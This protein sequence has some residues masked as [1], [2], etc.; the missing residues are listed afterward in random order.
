MRVLEYSLT[1][2]CSPRTF[3]A[4]CPSLTIQLSQPMPSPTSSSIQHLLYD[5]MKTQ[6]NASL[7][8]H[9]ASYMEIV[10]LLIF[11][12]EYINSAPGVYS[13]LH[14]K[15]REEGQAVEVYFLWSPNKHQFIL[16]RKH[17][18]VQHWSSHFIDELRKNPEAKSLTKKQWS[19]KCMV[20][21]S[22]MHWND[23]NNN[24]GSNES[25]W[26]ATW[27]QKMEEESRKGKEEAPG[28]AMCKTSLS[29]PVLKTSLWHWTSQPRTQLGIYWNPPKSVFVSTMDK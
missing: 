22:L 6:A 25:Q 18:G 21:P 7:S 19:Q 29:F 13:T 12:I 14:D 4:I 17:W 16:I 8:S 5:L 2:P 15:L 27:M 10:F 3:S 26:A 20:C 23:G 24:V 28:D 1:M 9:I 11:F